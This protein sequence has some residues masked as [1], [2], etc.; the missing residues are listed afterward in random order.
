MHKKFY[1]SHWLLDILLLFP[2][3]KMD[4]NYAEICWVGNLEADFQQVPL[5]S[6]PEHEMLMVSYCGQS[7]SVV[8]RPSCGVNNCFKSL[9]LLHPWAN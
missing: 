3:V 5:V 4:V 2:I 9:L 6:S 1:S 8:R 7:V